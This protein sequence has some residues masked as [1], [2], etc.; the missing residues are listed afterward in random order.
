MVCAVF[1]NGNWR[2]SLNAKFQKIKTSSH[3]KHSGTNV[4]QFQ[5]MVLEILSFSCKKIETASY[6]KHCGIKLDKY[7]PMVHFYVFMLYNGSWWP[8]WISNL[9]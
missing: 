4:D 8:F 5:Q 7:Q 2:P 9:H 6:K 3:K 1:S